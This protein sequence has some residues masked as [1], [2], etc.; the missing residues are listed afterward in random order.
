MMEGERGVRNIAHCY[1][2]THSQSLAKKKCIFIIEGTLSLIS[3]LRYFFKFF[4]EK[5]KY[6]FFFCVRLQ[7]CMG[8]RNMG[9]LGWSNNQL[10]SQKW[11]NDFRDSLLEYILNFSQLAKNN[12]VQILYYLTFI[13]FFKKSLQ[14]TPEKKFFSMKTIFVAIC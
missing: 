11:A 6:T 3:V 5:L 9:K 13:F 12:Y 8:G 7:N 1:L 10:L 4:E 2:L 14:Q